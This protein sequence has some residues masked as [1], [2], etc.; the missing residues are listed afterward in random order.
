[1]FLVR[2]PRLDAENSCAPSD[3]RIRQ[4]KRLNKK[5]IFRCHSP[6]RVPFAIKNSFVTFVIVRI[7]RVVSCRSLQCQRGQMVIS[8]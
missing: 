7:S 4:Q 1:M 3:F 8:K 6:E 5:I 2:K